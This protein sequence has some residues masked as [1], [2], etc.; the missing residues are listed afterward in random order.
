MK[1]L[2][3]SLTHRTLSRR[4]LLA[5][6]GG[7]A[8][9]VLV[10]CDETMVPAPAPTGG[11]PAGGSQ[12]EG[13]LAVLR[14]TIGVHIEPFGT[15]AQGASASGP[16]GND[17]R[18][19]GLFDRHVQDLKAVAAMVKAHGGRLTVQAQSPFTSVA[20]D[21]GSR[22]LEELAAEGHEI[23]LHLHE[24]AHLGKAS[25]SLPVER[26]CE[27]LTEEIA[28][29][30]QASGVERIRYWSG[31][32]L[33]PDMY[34]AA[35]CAGLDV[36]SDWKNPSM[37]STPLELTGIHPWRPAGGTDG[38]D[39][40]SFGQHDAN[41]KVVFLPEGLYDQ[42]N[43]ASA[44]RSEDAR[45]RCRVLRLPGRTAAGF[46]RCGRRREGEC[47]PLHHPPRRIPQRCQPAIR[48]HRRLSREHGRPARGR[49][50]GAV[51]DAFGDG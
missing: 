11:I 6:T 16:R 20:I 35:V 48:S 34:E 44:R 36:N 15:T 12:G 51:G 4:R 42:E 7:A 26:W 39:F 13:G 1:P 46:G 19:G 23:A 50:P 49:R 10:G 43:F 18:S 9:L 38:R 25:S 29:V 37:Q 27:V 32:N 40:S 45:G 30:R 28:L 24:D 2:K 41:G 3:Y 31:G 14:F 8:A 21:R 17:Y 47:P 33:Y 5:W 22:V